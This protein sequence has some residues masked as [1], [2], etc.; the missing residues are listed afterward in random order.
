M[1]HPVAL[2]VRI[3]REKA[4]PSNTNSNWSF[5]PAAPPDIAGPPMPDLGTRQIDAHAQERVHVVAGLER[6]STFVPSCAAPVGVDAM[7][8]VDGSAGACPATAAPDMAAAARPP[9]P[10]SAIAAVQFGLVRITGHERLL[11]IVRLARVASAFRGSNRL[12]A[13][14]ARPQQIGPHGAANVLRGGAARMKRASRRRR[15]R[16]WRLPRSARSGRPAPVQSASAIDGDAE[17]N[18]AVY[19]CFGRAITSRAGPSSTMRP[20]YMTATRSEMFCT[21]ARSCAIKR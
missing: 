20:R 10:I 17:T 9:I 5:S 1:Q 15:D 14:R 2:L 13:S 7:R 3:S 6:S 21:S 11:E 12:P 8:L 19:G 4:K 16:G 18:A